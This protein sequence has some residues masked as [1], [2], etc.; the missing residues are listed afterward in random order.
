MKT[1]LMLLSINVFAC[2]NHDSTNNHV[3]EFDLGDNIVV[4]KG[5]YKNCKG[6][7]SHMTNYKNVNYYNLDEVKCKGNNI[8]KVY[9][10]TYEYLKKVN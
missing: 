2:N 9:N 4:T 7:V 8:G 3:Y 6:Y 10:F 1:I 5:K